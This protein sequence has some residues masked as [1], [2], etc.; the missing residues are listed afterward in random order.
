MNPKWKAL[1]SSWWTGD[2]RRIQLT[3]QILFMVLGV[4]FLGFSITPLQIALTVGTGV[5]TQALFLRTLGLKNVGYK[6]A[7]NASLSVCM[8]LRSGTLWALPLAAALANASK[9][10]IRYRG[11]HIYNPSNFGIMV[12]LMLFPAMC[13]M[14]PAQWGYEFYLG[15]LCWILGSTIVY[16]VRRY[17]ISWTFF[18]GYMVLVGL[19]VLLKGQD[20]MAWAYEFNA[21]LVIFAFFMISDPKTIPNHRTAR[22]FYAVLLIVVAY[23]LTNPLYRL[24]AMLWMPS[25]ASASSGVMAYA[26]KTNG[27]LLSLFLCSPLVPFLDRFWRGELY[28]WNGLPKAGASPVKAVVPG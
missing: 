2:P 14:V 15:A 4:G 25:G 16:R 3:Y 21:G 13:Y 23:L 20:F 19:R 10:L 6:S 12:S 11:K 7:L 27:I 5:L 22:V 9:F 28:Q 1:L 18:A 24:N 26:Y 17:D 8:L